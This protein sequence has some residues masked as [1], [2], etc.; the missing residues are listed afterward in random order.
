MFTVRTAKPGAGNK[1]YIRQATGGW[2]SCIQGSPTD[3]QCNVLAN[4]V[5]Y[6]NGRFNEI[7]NEITGNRSN[8]YNT[9]NCNAEN[10]IERARNAGLEVGQ[11][12]RAGAIMCWQKGATLSGSDG[13]GHVA[14]VERVNSDGS[15]YTSESGYG[16]SAFWNQTRYNNNGRW[17]IGSGYTFR[18]FI[19]NPAVKETQPTPA[20]TPKK[21]LD[22]IAKDVIAGKYGNYPER[23]TRLEAEGYNYSQ[24]Q[25]RVNELVNSN[26]PSQASAPS[27]PAGDDLLTLVK[28]TIRGDF[29]NGQARRN[30]LGSRYDEVQRQVNLNLK[31][32]LSRWDNIRLF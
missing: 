10:F 14:V 28:K 23:K 21:S 20:A 17:G 4:C 18:G 24:V 7:Y 9:L 32:G 8:K 16:S 12:P 6:A 3:S 13:A 22:E 26:K 11:T 30:A 29:G 1:C 5:G 2:N 19:Y 31:N 27:Q 15:V 25:G